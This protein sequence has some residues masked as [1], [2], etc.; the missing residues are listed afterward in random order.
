MVGGAG[1]Y[2]ALEGALEGPGAGG[3]T[4]AQDTDGA[5]GAE[6]EHCGWE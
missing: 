2:E 4:G 1:L 5:D 3:E 6:A